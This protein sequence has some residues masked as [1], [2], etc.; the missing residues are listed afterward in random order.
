MQALP[1]PRARFRLFWFLAM[2]AAA[3]AW[4]TAARADSPTIVAVEEDWELVVANPDA[5]NNAPQVTCVMSPG[6]AIGSVRAALEINQQTH[7]RYAP[8]GV[9]LQLWHGEYPLHEQ[10]LFNTAVMAQPNE[11]VT[12]TQTMHLASGVLVFEVVNG[13]STTWGAFGGGGSLR[14][15]CLTGLEDLNRYSPD[16]SAANSAV[17][18]AA[19]RVQSLVLKRVRRITSTGDVLE[20]NTPRP[21]LQ[22]E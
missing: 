9:Q 7:P 3:T 20:D 19:N 14:V 5:N 16:V 22:Q 18:F 6:G 11:T 1:A 15:V 17:G 10:T 2:F 4:A 21:V 13:S 12:W 8:G